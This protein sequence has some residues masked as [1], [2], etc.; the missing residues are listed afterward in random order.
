MRVEPSLP[1]LVE[2]TTRMDAAQGQNV[3]GA[4][5]TPKHARLLAAGTNDGLAAGLDDA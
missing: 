5:L 2:A 1:E 4:W 3:F